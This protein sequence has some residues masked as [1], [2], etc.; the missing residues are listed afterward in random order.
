MSTMVVEGEQAR[1]YLF[2]VLDF[3]TLRNEKI[4]KDHKV[5]CSLSLFPQ[6]P[7]KKADQTKEKEYVRGRFL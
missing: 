7:A 3:A 5:E 1:L 6:V 2:V 4:C